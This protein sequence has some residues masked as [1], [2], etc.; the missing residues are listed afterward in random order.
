M[1][2]ALMQHFSIN[3]DN[4]LEIGVYDTRK[5]FDFIVTSFCIQKSII[6]Q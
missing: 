3:L 2:R 5:L 4:K 6:M 1:P